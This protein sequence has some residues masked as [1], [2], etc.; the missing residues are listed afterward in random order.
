MLRLRRLAIM[1]GFPLVPSVAAGQLPSPTQEN[2]GAILDAGSK[3]MSAKEFETEIVQ[4]VIVGPAP[5]GGELEMMFASNGSISGAGTHP[6][7][8]ANRSVPIYGAWKLDDV[9]RACL[10]MR[11]GG[12]L[13]PE[14][15]QHWYKL[16]DKYYVSHS[17]LDRSAKV[18]SRTIKQ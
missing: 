9:G 11:I 13:L 5:T 2:L 7:F 8:E 17:D 18:L 16:A 1:L 10:S 12:L 6:S 4:R 14:R 15:C 3:R